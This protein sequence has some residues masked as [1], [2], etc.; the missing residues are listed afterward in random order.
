MPAPARARGGE[1]RVHL[2]P[3]ATRRALRLIEDVIRTYPEG[4]PSDVVVQ[5]L[6][7]VGVPRPATLAL[8]SSLVERR[9]VLLA[10]ERLVL[11]GA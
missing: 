9:R 2:E 8:L 10:G 5:R 7:R 11:A 4:A 1:E 3:W 6:A